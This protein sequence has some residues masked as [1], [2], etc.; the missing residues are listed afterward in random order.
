MEYLQASVDIL[1]LYILL[2]NSKKYYYT[3]AKY[4]TKHLLLLAF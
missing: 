2:L 1:K 3:N 4:L